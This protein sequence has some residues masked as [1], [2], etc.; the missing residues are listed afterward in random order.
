MAEVF[1]FTA[2]QVKAVHLALETGQA[3]SIGELETRLELRRAFRFTDDE[4]MAIG[5]VEHEGN[6]IDFDKTA[7]LTRSMTGKTQ[8][9]LV[10]ILKKSAVLCRIEFVETW[11]GPA[12]A[13]LG[14]ARLVPEEG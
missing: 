9:G 4:K 13:I 8:E 11:L 1:T 5:Y 14:F 10:A 7:E 2:G 12:L 3:A 6:G